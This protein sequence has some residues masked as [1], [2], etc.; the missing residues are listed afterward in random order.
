[1]RRYR[2]PFAINGQVS[3]FD[4]SFKK[5]AKSYSI[6]WKL[7]AAIAFKESRFNP[8]A[9]GS[10]GAYGLMQFMPFVASKYHIDGK[11]TP[12]NKFEQDASLFTIHT[13]HGIPLKAKNSALNSPWHPTTRVRDMS[14]MRSA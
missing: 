2:V 10:G 3:P 4:A 9:V 12:T 11:S 8:V 1:M 14:W 13:G 7:V 5:N 6:D